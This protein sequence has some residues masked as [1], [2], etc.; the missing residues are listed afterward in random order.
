MAFKFLEFFFFASI[1][2]ILEKLGYISTAESLGFTLLIFGAVFIDAYLDTL[3]EKAKLERLEK[4]LEELEKR[5]E[6]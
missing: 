5:K 4:F 6:G 1:F 2:A 3:L